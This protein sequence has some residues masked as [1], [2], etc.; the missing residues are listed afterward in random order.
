MQGG[1][2]CGSMAWRHGALHVT[3]FFF[4][5][6]FGLNYCINSPIK[7]RQGESIKKGYT[8]GRYISDHNNRVCS[9][10][11]STLSEV[12]MDHSTGN[13]EG[14]PEGSRKGD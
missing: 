9:L 11:L 2:G 6:L 13:G 1:L 4:K 12:R 5:V 3:F 10:D 8:L 14:R 7:Y